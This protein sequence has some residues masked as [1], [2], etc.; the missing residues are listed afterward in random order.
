[1]RRTAGA[2]AEG[3]VQEV[4]LEDWL[5]NQQDRGLNHAV[6]HRR[7]TQR[8]LSTVGLGD[9]DAAYG[10]RRVGL[11]A[12]RLVQFC[13]QRCGTALRVFDLVDRHPVGPGC[14]LVATHLLPRCH[15]HVGPVDPVVQ[16]VKP[17][18]RLLLGL[19]AEL[20]PQQ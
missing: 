12:Q 4:R 6:A 8:P 11:G 13:H 2:E 16:G 19:L 14:A 9:V 1:M 18:P 3:T 15:Q 20:Q 17:E 10:L 5:Q 7:D